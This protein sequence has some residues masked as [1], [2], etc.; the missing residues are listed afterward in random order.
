[1]YRVG[2]TLVYPNDG[3]SFL[4]CADI[5]LKKAE[6]TFSVLRMFDGDYAE[7]TTAYE[8]VI[9]F[10]ELITNRKIKV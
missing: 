7:K 1:V 2:A 3:K 6:N 9:K 4:S 10:T 5:A 8:S